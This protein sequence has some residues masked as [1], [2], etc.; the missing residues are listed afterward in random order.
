MQEIL[1]NLDFPTNGVELSG[2]GIMVQGWALSA[3][4]NPTVEILIDGKLASYAKRRVARPDV[5][6][7]YPKLKPDAYTSGFL[8]HVSMENFDDGDHRVR[9]IARAGSVEKVLGDAA[10]V[11]FKKMFKQKQENFSKLI[12]CPNDKNSLENKKDFL[13][14]SKCKQKFPI[15]NDIP[16]MLPDGKPGMQY[17]SSNHY[18]KSV[19]ELIEKNQ[20]GGG[21]ILDD[22]S[23]YPHKQFENVL[24]FETSNLPSTNVVG[25]GESLP[26]PD[27]SFDAVISQSVIEHVKHPFAYVNE[28]HRVCK[29]GGDVII[30]SA[31]MQ[32]VHNYP[33]HFFNTTMEGLKLLCQDFTI[34]NSS[35]EDYQHP[36]TSLQWMLKSYHEGL[37]EAAGKKFLDR[38]VSELI[39]EKGFDGMSDLAGYTL[40]E[41]AAGVHIHC[42]KE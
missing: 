20:S 3:D 11:L 28:I 29:K 13:Q 5:A 27:E 22:G 25:F 23:G 12:V 38:K 15:I 39:T 26:F 33:Q 9:V 4:A 37:D 2:Y 10:F 19:L 31:F 35:I 40:E 17:V 30:D 18:S 8:E 41:L 1:G 21:V 36:R 34:V 32:P 16:I 42:I 14:C 24:C 7:A 6:G